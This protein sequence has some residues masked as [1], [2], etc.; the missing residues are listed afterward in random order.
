MGLFD[1]EKLSGGVRYVQNLYEALKEERESPRPFAA[2][3][4]YEQVCGEIVTAAMIT[5]DGET[6]YLYSLMSDRLIDPLENLR[7]RDNH[8][9]YDLVGRD[10]LQSGDRIFADITRSKVKAGDVMAHMIRW[11]RLVNS[12]SRQF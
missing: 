8:V 7:D 11:Y 5:I 3:L 12:R 6:Q 1:R 10:F 4:R 2:G 9:H